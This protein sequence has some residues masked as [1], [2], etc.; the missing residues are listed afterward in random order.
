MPAEDADESE[1]A[2]AASEGESRTRLG[3][4][5]GPADADAW[6]DVEDANVVAAEGVDTRTRTRACKDACSSQKMLLACC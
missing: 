1:E 3:A 2:A 6:T 5:A 4:D